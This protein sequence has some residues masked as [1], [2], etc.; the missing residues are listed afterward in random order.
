MPSNVPTRPA[1]AIEGWS[2]VSSYIHTLP[3]PP[4]VHA[5]LPTETS[6]QDGSGRQVYPKRPGNA[7]A[8]LIVSPIGRAYPSRA[9]P[10]L[11][12]SPLVPGSGYTRSLIRRQ[13]PGYVWAAPHVLGRRPDESDLPDV[14][15][16]D[17][18]HGNTLGSRMGMVLDS[19]RS[20]VSRLPCDCVFVTKGNCRQAYKTIRC[21]NACLGAGLRRGHITH[22]RRSVARFDRCIECCQDTQ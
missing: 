13:E 3:V 8:C 20:R 11:L 21:L 15:Y 4:E 14:M 22:G 10:P 17:K 7:D 19:N 2:G 5:P 12:C 9:V 18:R 6:L 1:T 16:S